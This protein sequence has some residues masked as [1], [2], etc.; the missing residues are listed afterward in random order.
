MT[1]INNIYLEITKF[2]KEEIYC[3]TSQTRRAS[4]S[5][6]SNI[7]EDY[8]RDG[9]KDYLRYLNIGISSLFELQTQLEIRENWSF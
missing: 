6:P 9:K 4:I 3:L 8:R 7:A 1:L 5:I 2:P